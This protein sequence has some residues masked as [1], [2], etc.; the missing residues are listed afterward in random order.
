MTSAPVHPFRIS[1]AQSDVDDLRRRLES[2]RWPEEIDRTRPEDGITVEAMR[3]LV[4]RWRDG[5]DWRAHEADLNRFPQVTTEVDGQLLHAV[6]RRSPRPD[7][8]PL[9]LLHGWPSTVAEFRHIVDE[10]AEPA[11]PSAPAFHVVAPSLPGFGFSG[12][13]RERGWGAHRMADAIAQLMRRLGHGRYLAHGGDAGYQVAAALAR[14]DG[15]QVGGIHLNLGGVGLAGLH[16]D[17]PPADDAEARALALYTD[18][19][20]DKS[21]YALLNATRPQTVSYGLADSPI[22]QLAWIAEKFSDWADPA[23]PVAVDDV[24]TTTSIFWYTGTAASSARFYQEEYTA[25]RA[26]GT[27]PATRRGFVDVPTA[28]S[29][30][31][32]EI[33]PPIRRWAEERY[34]IVRWSELPAGGH[35]S[36]LERPDLLVGALQG[37]AAQ[38]RAMA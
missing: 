35:F 30:F 28:V 13:L 29:S 38:L 3:E 25:N 17:E 31:P 8:E 20:R 10:L 14:V 16:R 24:L 19:V 7:A 21:A 23:H 11:D 5:F 26:P 12:P 2:A 18:Y 37:F 34:R 9:V 32:S 1:V 6:H 22:G 4:D 33:V 15:D 36:A 27:G